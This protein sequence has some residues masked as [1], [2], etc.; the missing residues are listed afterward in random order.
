MPT[1]TIPP[2]LLSNRHY[3]GFLAAFFLV[4][5]RVAIGW[6]F[7]VEGL[8]KA[9]SVRLAKK[10]FSAEIYLRNA[11]GP[12]AP[13][14]RKMLPDAD[15]LALLDPTALKEAWADRV[16][17]LVKHYNLDADDQAKAKQLLDKSHEW[18]DVWFNG[19]DNREAREKYLHELKRTEEVERNPESLSY[20]LERAWDSRRSLETDRRTL[21]APIVAQGETLAAAVTALATPE[22]VKAAGD[23]VPAWTFLD[24]ANKLTTYGLCAMGVCLILGFLTPFA[25]VCAA[26]F[27]AMIYLSMPPLANSPPN[28]KAEGHYWIV[29]KN[30]VELIACLVV[31]TTASGHW[32]GLDALVFGGL[33]RR[34]WARYERRLVEKYGLVNEDDG[35][36]DVRH[37]KSAA[38]ARS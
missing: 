10:P 19:Y 12:L 21:T 15:G 20:D 9:E 38:V 24:V 37:F 36:G 11:A 2:W 28:P 26:A 31:A 1:Y 32:F 13:E 35:D 27:L 16:S 22:Q 3:P 33:R 23:F 25:A 34:R 29:N 4:L 17:A 14:F 5:L 30:L 18:I 8:D 7:L 6:H